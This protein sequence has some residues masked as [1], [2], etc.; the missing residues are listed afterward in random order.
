MMRGL[1]LPIYGDPIETFS[2]E[3]KD[4][5]VAFQ[6]EKEGLPA[7]EWHLTQWATRYPFHDVTNSSPHLTGDEF[8]YR[9]TDM[10]NGK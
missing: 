2:T 4:P 6:Y 9:F 10:G 7:P 3:L 8:N 5:M 1:N